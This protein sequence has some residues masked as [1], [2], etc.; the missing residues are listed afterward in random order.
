[1]VR[2]SRGYCF[3]PIKFVYTFCFMNEKRNLATPL[4]VGIALVI[5]FYFGIRT[6]SKQEMNFKSVS[7]NSNF[8]MLSELI[9]YIDAEYV[10]SVSK[11][12]LMDRTIIHL[13]EELD[14]HSYYIK[15]EDYAQMNE[16]LEGNFDGIGIQFNI[17]HDTLVVI[18]PI[19]G[20]PSE[21]VGVKAGDRIIKVNDSLIAGIGI[22]NNS[23][24]KLLKGPKGTKVDITVQRRGKEPID[25]TITRDKIP[26]HSVNAR[27][28]INDE[29]GYVKV[30]RF[31]AN[32]NEEFMDAMGFLSGK[33]ASKVLISSF[34]VVLR[35]EYF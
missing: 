8:N 20:G 9:N 13:L 19:V 25:F 18:D 29:V 28:M 4:F 7:S 10:D 17:Q 11:D 35:I 21:K 34:H 32:T 14:P 16:P 27:Y 26:I 24:L 33:G 12:Q 6:S 2:Q 15:A 22:Q 31:G 1:M 30:D 23:V 5:G 3:V